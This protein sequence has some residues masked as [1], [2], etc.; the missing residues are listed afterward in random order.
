[1]KEVIKNILMG[2]FATIGVVILVLSIF[3]GMIFVFD[4]IEKNNTEKNKKPTHYTIYKC[5][6]NELWQLSEDKTYYYPVKD[7]LKCIPAEEIK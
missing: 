2:F 4:K 3:Y 5:M 7:S 6:H 1:M